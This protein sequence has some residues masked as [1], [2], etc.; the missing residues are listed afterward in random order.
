MDGQT[1][2]SLGRSADIRTEEKPTFALV[3]ILGLTALLS[4]LAQIR[5]QTHPLR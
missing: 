2:F 1:D 4:P 3:I 5:G